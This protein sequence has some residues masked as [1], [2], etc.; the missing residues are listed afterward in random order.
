MSLFQSR[1]VSPADCKIGLGRPC[2][3]DFGKHPAHKY[4]VASG[5]L[6]FWRDLQSPVIGRRRT[7]QSV[8]HAKLRCRILQ[9]T[10]FNNRHLKPLKGLLLLKVC[11]FSFHLGNG[12]ALQRPATGLCYKGELQNRLGHN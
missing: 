12:Y 1:L 10:F 9:F 3:C 6:Q 2:R 11:T 4:F 7:R 8:E 5:Q